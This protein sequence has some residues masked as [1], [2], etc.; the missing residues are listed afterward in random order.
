MALNNLKDFT[1]SINRGGVLKNNKY[2]A[3]IAFGR[4]HY[5]VNS[6][7]G[8][9]TG[10]SA[11]FSIRCDSV[12]LPGVSIAS[13]DGPPRLGYGPVQKHPYNINF[14]DINLTFIV[15]SNS[16]VHRMLYDWV[17]CIVDFKGLGG[18]RLTTNTSTGRAAYEVGYKNKFSTDLT[19]E[20]Y[21]DN[22]ESGHVK[23]MT[24]TAYQ[25]FPMAFPSVGLNW[26]EGDILKLSI[27]FSY[28]D[29]TVSY[30]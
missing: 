18:T 7:F 15:D 2:V 10:E 21:K 22:G 1:T 8:Y 28:T 11:L 12:Q 23:A 27:P 25:A 6:P 20:V 14:E 19:V 17:N 4:D 9:G 24:V 3:T 16:V 26:A 5:L 13:A 29:Y 30:P